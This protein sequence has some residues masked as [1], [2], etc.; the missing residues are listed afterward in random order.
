[1]NKIICFAVLS[2]LLINVN[3][4]KLKF[5]KL[6][7]EGS[8]LDINAFMSNFP[9]NSQTGT[10]SFGHVNSGDF[11]NNL[12]KSTQAVTYPSPIAQVNTPF[13]KT[14]SITP[15]SVPVYPGKDVNVPYIPIQSVDGG[16][17]ITTPIV[18]QSNNVGDGPK[19][20]DHGK[21]VN[22]PYVPI[23]SV[24][25]GKIITTPIVDQSKV[26]VYTQGNVVGD[27]HKH[28][29]HHHNKIGGGKNI[30]CPQGSY[31]PYVGANAV[32]GKTGNIYN[33]RDTSPDQ[34]VVTTVILPSPDFKNPDN[35]DD[36]NINFVDDG[37][38]QNDG[39][40]NYVDDQNTANNDNTGDNGTPISTYIS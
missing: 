23:Q 38:A 16:K 15:Q 11:F 7:T 36:G 12:Q 8:G 28:Y 9:F 37:S 5:K 10:T 21:D 20:C 19:H 26:P 32:K 14:V 2:L 33:I 18:D 27:A 30:D 3:S 35:I 22:S 34:K 25:G 31:I 6:E 17:I 13:L 1:M 29:H 39:N 4:K 40:I 24:D